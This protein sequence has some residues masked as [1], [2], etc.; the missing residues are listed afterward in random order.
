MR[1]APVHQPPGQIVADQ[2]RHGRDR[3]WNVAVERD[4]AVFEPAA[5]DDRGER[6]QRGGLPG[7]GGLELLSPLPVVILERGRIDPADG[8]RVGPGAAA[9]GRPGWPR[10][11]PAR[12]GRRTSCARRR[13]AGRA[14]P[15]SSP[16]TSPP[17]GA[18][19]R[20][21]RAV[22]GSTRCAPAPP[23]RARGWPGTSARFSAGSPPWTSATTIVAPRARSDRMVSRPASA[24]SRTTMPS[25]APAVGVGGGRRRR[26]PEKAD[27]RAGGVDQAIGREQPLAVAAVE[28]G[29][30]DGDLERRGQLL[31]QR[32]AD[33]QIALAWREGVDPGG[34][35]ARRQQPRLPCG[36]GRRPLGQEQ[37]AGVDDQR[38][39]R[40]GAGPADHGRAAPEATER[41][42]GAVAG[43]ILPL[44]VRR[45]EE[46]YLPAARRGGRRIRIDRGRAEAAGPAGSGTRRPPASKHGEERSQ[47]QVGLSFRPSFRQS[48]PGETQSTSS[49][50]II[51]SPSAMPA[52]R[53]DDPTGLPDEE[54]ALPDT[55]EAEA[56]ALDVDEVMPPASAGV[57]APLRDPV[58]RF[59]AE[60]RRFSASPTRRSASSAR[61]CASRGT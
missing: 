10:A 52:E 3:R 23:S 33:R 38:R 55:G 19:R 24:G 4:D 35:D 6:G 31:E 44:Q 29:R 2:A 25:A 49:R 54:A 32:H 9:G 27:A 34:R 61:R 42:D 15:G 12:P 13:R 7:D 56:A 60:A 14:D 11:R 40:L 22:P 17:A 59:L 26:H 28:V 36:L 16:R 46:R 50:A 8:W 30:N 21:S 51:I 18:R 39:V 5:G 48:F 20:P 58:G 53:D 1:P 57:L 45:V 41:L 37:V 43:E 47:G